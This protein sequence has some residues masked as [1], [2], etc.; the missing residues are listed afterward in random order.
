MASLLTRHFPFLGSKSGSWTR[1]EGKNQ[2][3][4][5]FPQG[6]AG[7]LF[8]FLSGGCSRVGKSRSTRGRR[9][10]KKEKISAILIQ[11]SSF[12]PLNFQNFGY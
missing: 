1:K 11:F 8:F 9:K 4:Y 5:R 3:L 6:M 10:K 2:A 12:K 7:F